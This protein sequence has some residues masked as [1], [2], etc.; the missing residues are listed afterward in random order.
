MLG[1]ERGGGLE[2]AISVISGTDWLEGQAFRG[3]AVTRRSNREVTEK[4]IFH[5]LIEFKGFLFGEGLH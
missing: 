5:Q 3:F 2:R 4:V 1:V